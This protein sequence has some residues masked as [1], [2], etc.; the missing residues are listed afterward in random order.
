MLLGCTTL[1]S[2]VSA[3]SHVVISASKVS[4]SLLPPNI[5]SFLGPQAGSLCPCTLNLEWSLGFL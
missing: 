1:S 3:E 2:E 4:I 5:T